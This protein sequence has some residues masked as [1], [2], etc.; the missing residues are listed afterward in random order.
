PAEGSP[1][2]LEAAPGETGFDRL[3]PKQRPDVGG[4]GDEYRPAVKKDRER[5]AHGQR[6]QETS[7]PRP[8]SGGAGAGGRIP[9]EPTWPTQRAQRVASSRRPSPSKVLPRP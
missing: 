9:E 4:P 7:R 2:R 3:G 5:D 6:D 1:A 8:V